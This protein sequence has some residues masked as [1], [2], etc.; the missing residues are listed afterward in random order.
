MYSRAIRLLVV[1]IGVALLA[2]CASR[3]P[4]SDALI[5]QRVDPAVI[6]QQYGNYGR[7]ALALNFYDHFLTGVRQS[8]AKDADVNKDPAMAKFMAEYFA[9]FDEVTFTGLLVGVLKK[10]FTA[11]E[12]LFIGVFLDTPAGK[13][14][15]KVAVDLYKAK[16][17]KGA[18]PQISRDVDLAWGGFMASPAGKKFV[19]E[20]PKISS[21]FP[22]VLKD[23]SEK[24]SREMASR[25]PPRPAPS[26]PK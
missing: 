26:S 8:S 3:A 23:Y 21:E 7:I 18:K 15:L 25:V 11:E 22:L 24:V 1:A 14:G 16:E 12:A 20:I 4:K 5:P 2:A 6:R 17:G 19:Q 9:H 13:E 10:H